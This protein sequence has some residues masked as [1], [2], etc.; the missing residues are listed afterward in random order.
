[1]ESGLAKR[2]PFDDEP[3]RDRFRRLCN[4]VPGVDLPA[5]KLTLY[6]SFPLL[7]LADETA[8][9][10]LFQSLEWFIQAAE[11]PLSVAVETKP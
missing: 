11:D 7:V 5:S 3:L 6:P 8:R 2:P 1:M 10:E 4:S 9:Q